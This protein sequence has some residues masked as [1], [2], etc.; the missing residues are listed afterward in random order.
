MRI[1]VL[2]VSGTAFPVQFGLTAELY[3]Q[4]VHPDLILGCSG[5]NVTGFALLAAQFQPQRLYE[6]AEKINGNLFAKSWSQILPNWSVGFFKGSFYDS[7]DGALD[8]FRDIFSKPDDITAVEMWSVTTD[9]NAGMCQLWCNRGKSKSI[10]TGDK[11]DPESVNC[12]GL[13][14]VNGDND[15]AAKIAIASA[16][17]PTVVPEQ[18]ID[19]RRHADGGVM[20]SSPFTPLFELIQSSVGS[21]DLHV[22]YI[23]SYDVH[24]CTAANYNN[25]FENG[26]VTLKEILRTLNVQDRN[27]TIDLLDIEGRYTC[28]EGVCDQAMLVDI[29]ERRHKFRRSVLELYPA[30]NLDINLINLSSEDIIST[31]N[32]ARSE[33]RYRLW[34]ETMQSSYSTKIN[35]K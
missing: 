11:F 33:Y 3:E 26:E 14:Y 2:P 4:S 5:G 31:M 34:I 30:R 8:L 24:G 17:I 1:L 20:Y 22:D 7:G 27:K 25:L 10:L 32:E 12:L 19:G 13:R 29:N 18:I 15:L 6:I 9:R 21:L 35:M 16:S 23:S 28:Q